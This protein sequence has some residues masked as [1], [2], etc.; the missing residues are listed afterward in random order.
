[1]RDILFRGMIFTGIRVHSRF[2][3]YAVSMLAFSLIH[4]MGYVGQYPLHTLALCY[5][6]YLPAS[7][8]LA[9]ALEYSGSI[10]AGICLHM[11]AN[12]IAMSV[13][14]LVK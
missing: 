6:Q 10:W 11:I 7:F 9:W 4:V 12:T 1:M 5:L 13:M 2:W 8:A 14:L 3:A